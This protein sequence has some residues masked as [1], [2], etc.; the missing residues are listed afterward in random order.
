[1]V[2]T[3]EQRWL[4]A[5]TTILDGSHLFQP[6]GLATAVD[7]ALAPLGVRATIHLV[8]EEQRNLRQV[9]RPGQPPGQPQPLATTMAGQAFAMVR[10]AATGD[11]GWCVPIVNGTDRLG[12]VEFTVAAG[13]PQVRDGELRSRFETVAGLIGHLITVTTHKGDFLTQV[14]RSRPMTTGA[15][16]LR[17]LLPPLT[18]ACERMVISA[19]LEPC[20]DV[21]GDGF[22]YAIDGAQARIVILD[23]V[24]HGL[25]ASL[26]CA[27]AMSALRSARRA[28]GDLR[29]QARAADVALAE[30]F[31]DSRFVTAVL[32]ELDLD[33]GRLR[34]I[35]AGH[36]APL[37]LRTGRVVQDLDAGRRMPLGVMDDVEVAEE[38]LQANDRLLLYTDG[39]TEAR[40][41][42]GDE[43]GV[44]RLI[45]LTERHAAEG[46]PPP[47]T[48]RRLAHAVAEHQG[49][50]PADDATL[51]L[52]EWSPVA[53][54]RSTPMRDRLGQL[55]PVRPT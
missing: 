42:A 30:Q 37:L 5:F 14:R 50:A 54:L 32:A 47:E 35:N 26:A 49:G 39:V 13:E 33:A 27:V 45:D 52:A 43:F 55:G 51:V 17:Q 31:P 10:S 24:G 41:A 11:G 36:P 21:G 16:L 3:V 34:Y 46:L 44:R 6:D 48:V 38:A 25:A 4:E 12:V 19:I 22:D 2:E 9:P 8:D 1:M 20:Y 18:S 15:E 29:E 23:A 40:D 28:G 7:E 53:V